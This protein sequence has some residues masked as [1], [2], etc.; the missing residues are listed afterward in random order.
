MKNAKR[1]MADEAIARI[2]N[3]EWLDRPGYV[4]ANAAALPQ[5]LAGAPG[6]KVQNALHG[7]WFGHP[8]HP[9]LVSIPIGGWTLALALDTLAALGTTKD[10]A[11][12]KT[13]DILVKAGAVGAVA[14]AATGLSDWHQ[15]HGRPRRVGLVHAA[16]NGAALALQLASIALRSRGRR[17]EGRIASASGWGFMFAG[18]YLGGHLVYRLRQGVD[19]ADR[20]VVPRGYQPVLPLAELQEDRPHR[21]EVWDGDERAQIPLVLVRHRGRISAMGARCSHMGGPLDE[22]WI[23]NGGLVCPWHGSRYDLDTCEPLDGPATCPQPR[24]RVRVQDGMI[25]IKREQEPGSAAVTPEDVEAARAQET[26]AAAA[27]VR[28]AWTQSGRGSVRAS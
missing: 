14:A 20:N 19:Q 23:L 21:V 24:Y 9:A 11:V 25:E 27:A 3:S 28:S 1:G 5:R 15:T 4:L 2:E 8:I 18:A 22:G 13:A 6:R 7:T 26:P 17:Q 16:M 12:D 10:S